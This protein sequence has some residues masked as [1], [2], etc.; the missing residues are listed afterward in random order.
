VSRRGRAAIFL[1]GALACAL[2][3]ATLAS[4]Y[5]SRSR[6]R[7]GPLRPVVVAGADLAAGQALGSRV[8]EHLEVRRVPER[9][10]PPGALASP[11]EALGRAPLA[12]IPRGA[13]LLAGQ[14][15]DP[16]ESDEGAPRLG[17]GRSPVEI[18][19]AGG[20]A[21]AATGPGAKVDV[22]VTTE[23]EDGAAG[24]T[25][26]AAASVLLLDLRE[27]AAAA[28]GDGSGA[29]SGDSTA[30]LALTRAQALR[31]IAAENFARQVRLLPAA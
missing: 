14:L 19:I 7:Y 26:V 20:G 17:R 31:L 12:A 28:P 1:A 24:R 9:F 27:G 3:A 30:T 29:P 18:A 4:G 2:L 21:I 16:G 8:A 5:G 23:P 10:V 6:E 11:A 25:Y 13:Y 15:A 22:V